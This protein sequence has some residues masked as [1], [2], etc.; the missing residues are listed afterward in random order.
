MARSTSGWNTA[1]SWRIWAQSALRPGGKHSWWQTFETDL[2]VF[3]AG[4]S[5]IVGV[6]VSAAVAPEHKG[7]IAVLAW[8]VGAVFVLALGIEYPRWWEM[9]SALVAGAATAAVLLVNLRRKK[10][11]LERGLS[12]KPAS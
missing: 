2:L 5:A 11:A 3:F 7:A 12:T 8:V 9:G 10:A 1:R 6:V 4:R